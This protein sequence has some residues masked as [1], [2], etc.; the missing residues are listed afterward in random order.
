[1][2]HFRLVPTRWGQFTIVARGARLAA[3]RLPESSEASCLGEVRKSFPD[4]EYD[5]RLMP[6]LCRAIR[7]YFSGQATEFEVRLDLSGFT[8]FQQKVICTARRIAFSRVLSYGELAE[9]AGFAGAAR[10]VGSV[11]RRNRFPVIV[12]CHRVVGA[13]GRLGGFSSPGGLDDKRRLLALEK[14]PNGVLC[15]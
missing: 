1:M 14:V 7:R 15:S 3:T 6:E 12:P 11:M 4:S 13:G 8:E 10:A 9:K 2:E 5:E